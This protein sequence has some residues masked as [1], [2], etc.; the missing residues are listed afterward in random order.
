MEGPLEDDDDV[1][2]GRPQGQ[3]DRGLGG[4]GA[5][6]GEEHPGVGDREQLTQARGQLLLWLGVEGVGGRGQLLELTGDRL[7]PDRVTVAEHGTADAGDGVEVDLA[8]GVADPEGA[9]L[10]L[11]ED[12]GVEGHGPAGVGGPTKVS[13]RLGHCRDLSHVRPRLAS[14]ARAAGRRRS[15][16][17]SR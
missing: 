8:L 9:G 16:R 7:D 1:A 17:P 15:S 6:V 12:G 4:L 11:F 13:G 5:G 14:G 10:A 2:T 3:L